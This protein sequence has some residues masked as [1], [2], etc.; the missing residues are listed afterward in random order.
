MIASC[1]TIFWAK[2]MRESLTH[3]S[4]EDS[5]RGNVTALDSGAWATGQRST[6]PK[7]AVPLRNFR[8]GPSLD[9]QGPKR[10][11][12][13]LSSLSGAS[14][15]MTALPGC[16]LSLNFPFLPISPSSAKRWSWPTDV[17]NLN[18]QDV[19]FRSIVQHCAFRNL[20]SCS[21]PLIISRVKSNYDVTGKLGMP[22]IGSSIVSFIFN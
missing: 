14:S 13:K 3:P 12:P 10:S 17:P 20:F 8:L 9:I 11:S 15:A 21:S 2:V 6:I 1:L 22:C 16:W 18:A 4:S 19:G 7:P 5:I